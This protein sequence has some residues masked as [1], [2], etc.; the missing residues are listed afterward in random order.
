MEEL[1]GITFV[2]WLV[3]GE[4]G[5]Y[6]SRDQKMYIVNTFRISSLESNENID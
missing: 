4:W 2:I 3:F 5:R 1:N 6:T